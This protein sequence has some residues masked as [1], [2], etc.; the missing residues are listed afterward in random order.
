MEKSI[1]QLLCEKIY[2]VEEAQKLHQ[3]LAA[4]KDIN[5]NIEGV[6][7]RVWF[8]KTI[9]Y[10]LHV[11]TSYSKINHVEGRGGRAIWT[12]EHTPEFLWKAIAAL[13]VDKPRS[14]H[15]VDREGCI[16]FWPDSEALGVDMSSQTARVYV[17]EYDAKR[18]A[19]RRGDRAF[20]SAYYTIGR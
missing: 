3:D 14:M 18:A 12:A 15:L 16:S 1:A 8:E 20:R 7:S 10:E 11:Y 13:S 9:S 19:R 5:I 17:D 6:K 4:G 2:G